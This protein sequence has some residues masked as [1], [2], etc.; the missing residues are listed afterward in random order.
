MLVFFFANG[1]LNSSI[2]GALCPFCCPAGPFPPTCALR[3]VVL[4]KF[5]TDCFGAHCAFGAADAVALAASRV[6][7][8]EDAFIFKYI[9]RRGYGVGGVLRGGEA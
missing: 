8:L 5:L 6:K 3:L 9:Y 7:S 1:A 4:E 2:V